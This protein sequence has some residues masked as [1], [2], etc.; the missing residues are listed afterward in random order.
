MR[1]IAATLFILFASLTSIIS[2]TVDSIKVEQT[3][4]LIKVHYKILNSSQSQVF[5]VTVYCSINGGLQSVIKNLSGDFGDNVIGGRP[6]YMVLWDVLKDV[7]EVKSVDFSVRAELLKDYSIANTS[8]SKTL[9]KRR[10][11]VLAAVGNPGPS[12]GVKLGYMESW[13]I[14]AMYL[15]GKNNNNYSGTEVPV[16]VTSFDVTKRIVNTQN[17]KVHLFTGVI[18]SKFST[19]TKT[20]H[21]TLG[22]KS[23][24]GIEGG[25]ICSIH[26]FSFAIGT[27]T[28]KTDRG[29]DIEI[30]GD[31]DN[32]RG[33]F[34]L[35][36]RF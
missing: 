16:F 24:A 3:G 9:S 10:F 34:G 11:Y 4:E 19:Q 33:Y 8:G 26:N 18:A 22:Y 23:L 14:S 36:Y 17:F 15:K 7:D 30:G 21:T 5:R 13:G 27:G 12:I 6:E 1:K 29:N 31:D 20:T 35:G 28:F 32:Y 2:Q 25:L